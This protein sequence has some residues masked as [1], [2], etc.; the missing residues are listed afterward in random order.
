MRP[1]DQ[2]IA[3]AEDGGGS[4]DAEGDG[5]DGSEGESGI[6]PERAEGVTQ[7]VQHGALYACGAPLASRHPLN[8]IWEG[9]LIAPFVP[10][11]A[12]A[13]PNRLDTFNARTNVAASVVVTE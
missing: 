11:T 7:V 10:G 2:S 8:N 6:L 3:Q 12:F 4:A 5:N 9:Q 1:Q 13:E